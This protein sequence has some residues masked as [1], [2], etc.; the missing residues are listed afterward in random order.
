[1]KEEISEIFSR[2]VW[3]AILAIMLSLTGK[4]VVILLFSNVN[5][6]LL[7]GIQYKFILESEIHM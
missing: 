3:N 7:L 6:L 1:M 5:F 2:E 4:R